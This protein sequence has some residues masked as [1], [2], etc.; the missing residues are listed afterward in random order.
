[1][2]DFII[3]NNLS[4]NS[5]QYKHI[6]IASLRE[7]F[8]YIGDTHKGCWKCYFYPHFAEVEVWLQ[9]MKWLT[10]SPARSLWLRTNWMLISQDSSCIGLVLDALHISDPIQEVWHEAQ[11][12]NPLFHI[13][14][15]LGQMSRMEESGKAQLC[16]TVLSIWKESPHSTPLTTGI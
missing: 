2:S 9:K 16:L 10:W 13:P 6:K 12:Q 7:F 4:P 3:G 5:V 15:S 14:G 11:S 8:I 1:M